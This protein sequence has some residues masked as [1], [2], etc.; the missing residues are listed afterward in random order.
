MTVGTAFVLLGMGLA[1]GAQTD[2]VDRY[3]SVVPLSK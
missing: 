2:D 1:L 3:R